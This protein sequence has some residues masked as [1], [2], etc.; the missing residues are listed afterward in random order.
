[1]SLREYLKWK[2]IPLL[3]CC[4][5][6]LFLFW[7]LAASGV[8]AAFMQILFGGFFLFGVLSV[9]TAYLLQK[10]KLE[11]LE[12]LLQS[13]PEQY[14]AGEVLP[15]PASGV[16]RYYYEVMKSVSRSAINAAETAKKEKEEYL[17]YV[18]QWIHEI[19]TPLTA[20]S[21]I[22]SNQKN[23][24][25]HSIAAEIKRADNLTETILYYARLRTMDRDIRVESF[26]AAAFVEEAVK[27]Q[28]EILIAAGISVEL[29]GD[30]VI[31]SDK[32]SLSFII[33]QLLINA[34]KY[35]PRCHICIMAQ[36]DQISVEDNGIGIPSYEITR[37]TDRGFTG[38]NGE[39]FPN[40]TGMGLY[41]VN[42]LCRRLEIG[43][44]VLSERGK[45]TRFVLDFRKE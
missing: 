8:S 13:L 14:L 37:I 7:F 42:Q 27:N 35:C 5:G 2:A 26:S 15:P 24:G 38:T 40:S 30:F 11:R 18:E 31:Y 19:K 44:S 41:I 28:M 6:M 3:F 16:E 32:K 36:N 1:M 25:K 20:C 22:L 39:A 23:G 12:T 29:D 17:E 45:Y 33:Q 43:F 9:S 4:I 10:R 34:A 21:L